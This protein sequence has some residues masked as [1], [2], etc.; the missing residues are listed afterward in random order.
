M[1]LRFALACLLGLAAGRAEAQV[2]LGAPLLTLEQVPLRV[3]LFE[4]HVGSRPLYLIR[5]ALPRSAAFQV[6]A[7]ERPT[8]LAKIVG[9][10]QG[11]ATNGG[12]YD[13]SGQAMGLVMQDGRE[14]SKLR[15]GGGSGVLSFGPRGFAVLHRSDPMPPGMTQALQS[16][17]RIVSGA[18][19]VIG[20][21]VSP[22]LD[23]RS[24]VATFSDGSARLYVVFASSASSASACDTRGCSFRLD[25][26]S[27]SAGVSL[28]ELADFLVAEGADA[29]L[30][31][32]GGYSTSFE[33]RLGGKRLRV[34]AFRATINA[35]FAAPGYAP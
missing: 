27:S 32:D 35:L 10:R 25:S 34:V 31:L 4:A 3:E 16:I 17:D 21:R 22:E 28:G 30:N 24:A 29:A 9:E 5:T 2:A 33:A 1:R 7:A 12:F 15:R 11:V 26:S 23:A 14:V 8:P 13:E 20:P 6:L 18:K 19:S